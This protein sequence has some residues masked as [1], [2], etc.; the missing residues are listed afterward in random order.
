M[1]SLYFSYKDNEPLK[2]SLQGGQG[3]YEKNNTEKSLKFEDFI[4]FRKVLWR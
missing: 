4:Y 1:I 3:K 2:H